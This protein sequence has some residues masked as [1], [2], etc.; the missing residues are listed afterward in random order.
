MEQIPLYVFLFV[1]VYVQVFLFMVLIEE[2]D[3][4]FAKSENKILKYFPKVVITVHCWNEEKTLEK[5]VNSLLALNYPKNKIDIY[6]VNDG[7]TDNTKEVLEQ[8]N[9][10]NKFPNITIINKENGGKH[11]AMNLV[12][13]KLLSIPH[14]TSPKIG[15]E[16][17]ISEKPEIFGCLDADSYVFPDTLQNMLK[18]FEEDDEVMATTPML[19]VRKPQN[20]LQELL[21]PLLYRVKRAI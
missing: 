10:K 17:N 9:D 18:S 21:Y 7:S 11:T 19:I 15:E 8:Y 2:W 13:E 6:L 4:I 1:S 20:I 16:Q 3:K 5:T 14:L 12:L